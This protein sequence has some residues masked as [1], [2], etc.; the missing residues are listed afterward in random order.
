MKSKPTVLAAALAASCFALGAPV[1]A[2][3]V[4][5]NGV[6]AAHTVGAVTYISGGIGRT[7]ADA[8]KHVAKYYPLELEFLR[9][10]RPTDEYLANVKVRIK[11]AHDR[12]VLDVA[13][14]GP[15]LL[16]KLPSGKYTVSVEHDGRV[17]NREVHVDSRD[18]R[19]VVFDW[20]A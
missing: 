1:L 14:D 3:P 17:Q 15:F 12:M 2:A 18:H 9:K 5:G 10:A 13:S 19:R 6:P 8:I 4:S 7:E 11:D 20:R 16:A